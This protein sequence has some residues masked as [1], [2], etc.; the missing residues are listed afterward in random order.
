M[1]TFV[2][3]KM[4]LENFTPRVAALSPL[5][6]NKVHGTGQSDSEE[7][8]SKSMPLPKKQSKD[9]IEI[10]KKMLEISSHNQPH[11]KPKREEEAGDNE[12]PVFKMRKN[13]E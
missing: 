2:V 4:H 10:I 8:P 11:F 9:H 1:H 13:T 12:G 3:R 5:I 6:A 7:K